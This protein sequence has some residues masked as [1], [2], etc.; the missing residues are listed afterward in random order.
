MI[1]VIVVGFPLVCALLLYLNR[2]AIDPPAR[3][4]AAK[5][6]LRAVDESITYLFRQS[7]LGDVRR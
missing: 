1:F 4:E 6:R 5:R 2:R 3:S 7:E